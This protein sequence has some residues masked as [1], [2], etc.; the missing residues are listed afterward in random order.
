MS[1][2]QTM[3]MLNPATGE[4]LRGV[5]AVSV[6]R[7]H[8]RAEELRVGRYVPPHM[9][10]PLRPATRSQNGQMFVCSCLVRQHVE[11]MIEFNS[12][13]FK[14]SNSKVLAEENKTCTICLDAF[15][16][17]EG[18][19][20]LPCLHF[21]HLSCIDRWLQDSTQCPTCRASITDLNRKAAELTDLPVSY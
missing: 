5:P 16:T 13:K 6:N 8:R 21:F 11:A 10:K 15:E 19:R 7:I 2:V 4:E 17:G 14:L 12:C 18:L 3:R 20:T 1:A 9:R